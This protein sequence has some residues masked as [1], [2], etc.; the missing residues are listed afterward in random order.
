MTSGSPAHAGIDLPGTTADYTWRMGS[1]AHA[2]IDPWRAPGSPVDH[3]RA[4]PHTRGSTYQSAGRVRRHLGSP[5]HAGIDLEPFVG[6]DLF[7]GSPAHAG[8]D[9]TKSWSTPQATRL[10]RT[11]GDR[12]NPD[13][14]MLYLQ[15]APPHTRGST[16]SRPDNSVSSAGSPAHAGIDPFA[17][18]T[19]QKSGRLPRTR[20]DRPYASSSYD[21][22]SRAPPHT[23]GST[24]WSETFSRAYSGSPAHAGIDLKDAEDHFELFGLPR[25]RGDR[26]SRL[27]PGYPRDRA[28]PHTR[29]STRIPSHL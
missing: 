24:L 14:I 8:I 19:G 1:P 22:I 20:G 18:R 6:G 26:P 4:P 29:G 7:L 9:P 16:Q 25:T 10:P 2:G 27:L 23:R 13:R 21:V 3:V 28:P 15:Q 11:R 12:P 5:A 17:C